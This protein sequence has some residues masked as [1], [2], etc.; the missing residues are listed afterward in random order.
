VDVVGA[1]EPPE[2]DVDVADG[3]ELPAGMEAE[4]D[5]DAA[6]APGV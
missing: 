5:E 4:G 2:E 6:A 3:A 1:E